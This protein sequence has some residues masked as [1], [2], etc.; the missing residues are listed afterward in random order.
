MKAAGTVQ[1]TRKEGGAK[2]NQEIPGELQEHRKVKFALRKRK[3]WL[4]KK[5]KTEQHV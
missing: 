4:K 5:T 3:V 1:P 2:G